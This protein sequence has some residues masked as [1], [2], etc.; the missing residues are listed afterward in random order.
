MASAALR[1][2]FAF[3]Q[4]HLAHRDDA[5]GIKKHV[6]GAAQPDALGAEFAR[7][8]GV[9]RGIGIGADFQAADL[10]RPTHQGAE[11]AGQFGTAHRTRALEDFAGGAIDG[12]HLAFFDGD[13]ART[14]FA[15]GD[16]DFER[17]GA[18]N[19]GPPHAARH[20]RGVG[21]HAAPGGENAARCMHA[22]NVF[23]AGFGP[24]QDDG[25]LF[26]RQSFGF[27][28]GEHHFAGGGAWRGAQTRGEFFAGRGGIE[29]GM[30][31]LIERG[32]IDAQD[33]GVFVDQPLAHH[34]HRRFQRGFGGALARAGLQHEQL[35]F[36]HG[37]FDVLH[38][39]VMFFQP[40]ADGEKF[41]IGFG[42]RLFQRGFA[43]ALTAAHFFCY[44]LRG[45]DAR[46]HIFALG[47]DQEFAIK[48]LFAGGR[49][50]GEG[51]AGGG[52]LTAIAEHHGL[53]GDGGA[54]FLRDIVELA[55]S[56]G[57]GGAPAAEH[58]ADGAPELF[59]DIF[60]KRLAQFLLH[61]LFVVLGDGFQIIGAEFGI[62]FDAFVFLG[63]MDDLFE[64]GMIH[65]QHDIGIH[66]DEAAIAVI[67]KAR[68]AG[69]PGQALGGFGVE[70]EVEHG[71]H[72]AGH[73]DAGA[74]AHTDQQRLVG[75]AEIAL[76]L[77]T[78]LAQR[79]GGLFL[80]IG[81]IGFAMG[82]I[83]GADFGGDGKARRNRQADIAHLGQIGA[84]AAEKI[85]HS[86][87]AFGL[88]VAE[89]VDPFGHQLTLD[90]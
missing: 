42:H 73:G 37:E 38:V 25:A 63:D 11:I 66:L 48:Q 32:R 57:P 18:G 62:E 27:L 80:Q 4:D 71:V 9:G 84:L 41:G 26:G 2:L 1:P 61:Q 12:D 10:I 14:H 19:A 43:P 54:P 45:A 16:V 77:V 90:F 13:A 56:I 20:H 17:A 58:R 30:E 64:M 36:L 85:F 49:I 47:V 88:T 23:R 69:E 79:R 8:R 87:F 40:L 81:G 68:I 35:A 59:L 34:I 70:A 75:I 46:H 50:A 82:V 31:Q 72:H 6:F 78:D 29:C 21:G 5:L 28:G 60:R 33:G 86:R 89:R 52:G 83:M 44:R 67:G 65:P 22:V 51:D 15:F 39:A 74:G 3:S 55:V 24:H 76:G 7:R 53:D